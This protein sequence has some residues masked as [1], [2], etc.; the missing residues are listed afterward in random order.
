MTKG[1]RILFDARMVH[2]RRA[3]I[4]Q[5]AIS[6]LQAL[7]GLPELGERTSVDVLQM[8]ADTQPIVR[9]AR[10][11]R[12]PVSTPPHN[13][14]EQLA[15]PVE[16]LRIRP[17]PGI[18]HC[19][20]FVPPRLR[21]FPAV[22][23]IQ[24]LAFLKF[25]ELTLLTAESKRYY[26]QVE[27]AARNADALIALSSSARDDIVELLGVDARKVAVIPAAADARFRPAHDP[28][29]AREIADR[30]LG[31]GPKDGGYILFVGTIEPRKNLTTLV[32]A[33]SLLRAHGW[34]RPMPALVV[35]GKR[36]WLSERLYKRI[37]ELNLEKQVYFLHGVEDSALPAFYAGARVFALPSLYEGFGLPALEALASGTPV[38]SSNAGSLREVV[39]DA[40]VLVDPHDVDAWVVA[41]ES[42]LLDANFSSRL[43]LEGPRQAS[44]FSWKRA[45][46]ETL[47]LY[48]RIAGSR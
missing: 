33:Y 21:F 41:L 7:A 27:W 24:D 43:R 5:Y 44:Q 46:G 35:V 13:R 25:P 32:E 19:P 36:G 20:D 17:R 38:V 48:R 9:D 31:L 29:K 3:G 34:L 6:L 14:F 8:R 40:G 1:L 22:V 10:F 42:V 28:E 37:E 16:L 23:N 4:G 39:G 30:R 47:A 45:G 2:Y 18:M 15:L 12:V 26:G 11:R